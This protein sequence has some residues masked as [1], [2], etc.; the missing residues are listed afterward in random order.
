M[1]YSDPQRPQP[2]S[3]QQDPKDLLSTYWCQTPH[4][5][6]LC[7][8]Q[9]YFSG[10]G[11]PRGSIRDVLFMLCVF[12]KYSFH[13]SEFSWL[14][15]SLE[16][17]IFSL[18]LSDIKSQTWNGLQPFILKAPKCCVTAGGGLLH[19]LLLCCTF[20]LFFSS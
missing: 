12:I 18:S 3:I 19:W 15:C 5:E 4:P 16:H 13:I 2:S 1:R 9:S 8:V 6:V 17:S 14:F 7:L 11:T 20:I 10:T